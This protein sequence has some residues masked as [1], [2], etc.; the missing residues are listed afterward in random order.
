M[1]CLLFAQLAVAAYACPQLAPQAQT[2]TAAKP[3]PKN[4]P[5]CPE[6]DKQSPSLCAAHTN[7]GHQTLDQPSQPQ[8]A[9]FIPSGLVV[10][11]MQPEHPVAAG[12]L[13]TASFLETAGSG[14][15]LAIRHCCLRI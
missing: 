3:M 9:P 13:V 14:P 10:E 6:M 11:V 4:M 5:G 2:H 12:L 7:P 1:F 15:P 8:V